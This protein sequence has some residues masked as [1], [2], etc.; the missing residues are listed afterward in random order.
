MFSLG[1]PVE[2]RELRIFA[3]VSNGFKGFF[4]QR[5]DRHIASHRPE[6]IAVLNHKDKNYWKLFK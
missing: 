1:A 3:Q 4:V 2:G 6:K 5:N